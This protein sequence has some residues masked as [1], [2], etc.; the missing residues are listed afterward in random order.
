MKA[1]IKCQRHEIRNVPMYAGFLYKPTTHNQLMMLIF[2]FLSCRKCFRGFRGSLNPAVPVHSLFIAWWWQEL[3]IQ[4]HKS[5]GQGLCAG[6][7]SSAEFPSS[8]L[9]FTVLLLVEVASSLFILRPLSFL[10][11]FSLKI[12]CFFK[13]HS[14]KS[15]L[16]TSSCPAETGGSRWHSSWRRR[17][18]AKAGKIQ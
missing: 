5:L 9:F 13:V 17:D 3:S 12:F 2:L 1:N 11:H 18:L 16:G 15:S 10:K 6:S 4:C 8:V 14:P 7:G